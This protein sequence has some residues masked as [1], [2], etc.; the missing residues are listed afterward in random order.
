MNIVKVLEK[1]M[2]RM[3]EEKYK[4]KVRRKKQHL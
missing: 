1:V 2:K 4:E 3:K